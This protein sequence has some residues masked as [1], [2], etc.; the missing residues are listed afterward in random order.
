GL[1]SDREMI[2]LFNSTNELI[3]EVTYS[4]S[5]NW[6]NLPNG[7]GPTLSLI[8]PQTDNSIAENWKASGLYGTP[9]RLNDVYTK[10][11]EEFTNLPNEFMLFQNYP[12]P[13]NPITYIEYATDQPAIVTLSIYDVLGNLVSSLVNEYKTSGKYSVKFDANQLTSGIYF[14]RLTSGNNQS[15]K[16][17]LLIR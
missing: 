8:N 12:N 9:G 2:K 3:D 16:K 10:G 14:Y 1:S 15:V 11:E 13:F 17:M 6:T 4:S 5:G 7:N